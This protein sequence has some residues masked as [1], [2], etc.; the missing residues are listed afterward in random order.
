[1]NISALAGR[2]S[3]SKGFYFSSQRDIRFTLGIKRVSKKI[4]DLVGHGNTLLEVDR[5]ST[6]NMK[7]QNTI[8]LALSS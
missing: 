5:V 1:M 2:T 8:N 6:L 4:R 7:S 3:L